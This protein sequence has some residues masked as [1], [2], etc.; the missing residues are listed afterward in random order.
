[1]S[2]PR[3]GRSPTSTS[4]KNSVPLLVGAASARSGSRCATGPRAS[5][6]TM[7]SDSSPRPVGSL[8]PVRA[9]TISA[10]AS[11]TPE[12][13]TFW[14]RSRSRRCRRRSARVERLCVFVPASG[15]V[16]AKA[17]FVVPA[18]M[19]RSQRSFCSVG[20]V[21]RE[22]AAGDR[23]RDD[24]QQQRAAGAR[25]LLAHRGE[26]GHPAPAAVV[27]LGDVHAE[28]ALLAP[29][30]PTARVGGRPASCF[31][32]MYARAERRRDPGHGL[33]QQALLVGRDQRNR[34]HDGGIHAASICSPP[35]ARSRCTEF[36]GPEVLAARRHAGARAGRRRGPDQGQP[37]RAQLRRHPPAPRTSY[38]AKATLPLVPGAGGR[39]RARGH[40]RARRRAVRHRRLRR[41]RDRA[42]RAHVPDPRRRRRRHG[43]RAAAPGPDRLAPLPH[44][45]ARAAR[46]RRVV[47]HAAAG[48]VGSLAVQLGK[49][50]GAGRVIAD[51]VVGGQ[52]RR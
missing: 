42:G 26:L 50:L 46:A 16:T 9:T 20:A 34:R 25:Q 29:A 1:M 41:V 21:P 10:S 14:P 44:V 11:S 24:E 4:S 7:N 12:M 22:D 3:A 48:G 27:L 32:R 51:R 37:R 43:A 45:R 49:P 23:G 33:A 52:A 28:V 31:D 15:S 5:M 6:S 8:T 2:A 36:G 30:R 40:R 35:C 39:G 19:P 38:L 17:I 47:V 18:P 13:K